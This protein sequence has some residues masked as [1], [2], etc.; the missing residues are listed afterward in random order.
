MSGGGLNTLCK[1]NQTGF[2]KFR[3]KCSKT[4]NNTLCENE[5]GCNEEYCSKR[6]PKLCKNIYKQ[7]NVDIKKTVPISTKNNQTKQTKEL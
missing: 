5:N 1:F 3:Q 4:H 7:V 6:H 2:C